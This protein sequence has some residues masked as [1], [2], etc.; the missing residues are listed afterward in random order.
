[1]DKIISKLEFE[2]NNSKEY[3]VE[4][5]WNC[6]IYANKAKIHLPGLY[7][8]V[9]WKRYPEEENTWEPLYSSVP[10]KAEQFLSQKT[11]EKANSNFSIYWFRFA[12]S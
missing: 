1:M 2:A 3:K 11:L 5:I 9:V 6:A 7:Y 10:K 4:T 8:L 12:N